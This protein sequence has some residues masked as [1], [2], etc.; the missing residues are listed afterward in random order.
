MTRVD[1]QRS[2]GDA[3]LNMGL[4]TNN[5]I[6]TAS[7]SDADAEGYWCRRGVLMLLGGKKRRTTL[8]FAISRFASFYCIQRIRFDLRLLLRVTFV[9]AFA[10]R[11]AASCTIARIQ[12]WYLCLTPGPRPYICRI[13][14]ASLPELAGDKFV[15]LKPANELLPRNFPSN[16]GL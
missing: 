8:T 3:S 7:R 14:K 11:R 1:I 9:V 15:E 16:A 6:F 5:L 4:M 10:L 2:C 13:K 12:G